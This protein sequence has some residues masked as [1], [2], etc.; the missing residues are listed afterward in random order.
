MEN[1]WL[2]NW[3]M[4]QDNSGTRASYKLAMEK[5]ADFCKTHN[6]EGLDTIVSDYRA[7]RDSPDR[8]KL[9]QFIDS[10]NDALQ[11]YTISLKASYA[12]ATV[13]TYLAGI[14]SFF[15][16]SKV[17]IDVELPRNTYVAIPKRISK[18]KQSH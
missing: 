16:K 7:A 11:N 17:P 6:I 10:W 14:Q 4:S 9:Q 8:R 2:Q 18:E 13:K 15:R 1:Q 5:F 12:S 3:L